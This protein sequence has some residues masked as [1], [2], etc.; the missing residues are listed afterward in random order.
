MTGS[1]PRRRRRRQNRARLSEQ[2]QQVQVEA[3]ADHEDANRDANGTDQ[4]VANAEPESQ[5]AASMSGQGQAAITSA[6]FTITLPEPF[7]FSKPH[8]WEK[9]VRC[10]ERFRLASNLNSSSD[11]NQVN[12]LVYCMGDE[13][14]DVLRGIVLTQ[15]QRLQYDAVKAGFDGYF[16]PKKNGEI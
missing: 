15:Q 3:P 13:A 16:V 4:H 9:R 1:N 10:F 14:N 12:T 5:G 11:A 2:N 7:N 8:E 6:T